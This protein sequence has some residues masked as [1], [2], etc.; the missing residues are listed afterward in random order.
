[1]WWIFSISVRVIFTNITQEKYEKE[2]QAWQVLIA[3]GPNLIKMT[4]L[5]I[6]EKPIKSANLLSESSWKAWPYFSLAHL[7]GRED[8]GVKTPE[9]DC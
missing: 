8:F 4:N 2:N 6:T 3:V 9:T 5:K 1:M 7:I